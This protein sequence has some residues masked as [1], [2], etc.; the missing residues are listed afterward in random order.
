MDIKK[1]KIIIIQKML[2]LFWEFIFMSLGSAINT[3]INIQRT[4]QKALVESVL[5]ELY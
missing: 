4:V 2:S 3:S 5:L 1:S